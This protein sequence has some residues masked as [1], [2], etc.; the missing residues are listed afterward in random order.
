MI[1]T[2]KWPLWM[3]VFLL[4]VTTWTMSPKAYADAGPLSLGARGVD[5]VSQ[6]GHAEYLGG[7]QARLRLPLFFGVEGSADYRRESFGGTTTHQ[8]PLMVSGL[9]YLPKIIV[10][11]PFLLGGVGWYNSTV[12]GPN[13]F[14]A[15]QN[16]FGPHAGGGAEFNLSSSWFLD[17]TYRYV[18]LNKLHTVNAQ[19]V[20]EDVRDSGHMITAGLNYRL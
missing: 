10:V 1:K 9:L 18:W 5:Y 16:Q 13:G 7:V 19:G 14:S 8:W 17:A 2:R 12:H 15:T 3:G 11:Q 4:A 20:G 6:D